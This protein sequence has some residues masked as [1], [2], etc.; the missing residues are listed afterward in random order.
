MVQE[1][2]KLTYGAQQRNK[3]YTGKKCPTLIA[4][5]HLDNNR[6]SVTSN[7]CFNTKPGKDFCHIAMPVNEN[8]L[9]IPNVFENPT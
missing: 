8:G 9:L 5:I 3:I 2:Q 4:A 1:K 7:C 6:I